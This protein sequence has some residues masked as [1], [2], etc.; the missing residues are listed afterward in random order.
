MKT[1]Y[2]EAARALLKAY[3][4]MPQATFL[5]WYPRV[6][7]R[8]LREL[9]RPLQEA[10]LPELCRFELDVGPGSGMRASG[11]YAVNPPWQLEARVRAVMPKLTEVLR[12]TG[13][14]AL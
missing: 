9:E 12:A 7:D 6:D 1:D 10:K 4:R 5:L 11:V 14:V 2:A 13:P 8:R 3:Q